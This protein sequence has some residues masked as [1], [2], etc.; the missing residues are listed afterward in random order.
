MS[1]TECYR[2]GVTID[3]QQHEWW[4]WRWEENPSR[5]NVE[6][7]IEQG[8]DFRDWFQRNYV[9]CPDCHTEVEEVFEAEPKHTV[10]TIE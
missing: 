2:C 9:L 8:D 10:Q 4:E 7:A 5:E 3:I 6:E 1:E